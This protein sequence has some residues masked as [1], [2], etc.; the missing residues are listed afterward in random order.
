MDL[1]SEPFLLEVVPPKPPL[2]GLGFLILKR[3]SDC[4]SIRVVTR[5]AAK[6][7]GTTADLQHILPS[8]I[9]LGLSFLIHKMNV[10]IMPLS[11]GNFVRRNW[12]KSRAAISVSP[13]GC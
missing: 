7:L 6:V 10:I 3:L 5:M 2:L 1:C 13:S 9:F 4:P 8:K 12:K 11:R